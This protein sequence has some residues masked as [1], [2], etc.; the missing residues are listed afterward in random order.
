[1]H[2][3]DPEQLGDEPLYCEVDHESI[4]YSGSEDDY[5][6]APETRRLRIEA[7]AVQFLNGNVPYLLSA[8]LQGPFDKSSWT[9][10]WKSKRAERQ[11]NSCRA[12]GQRAVETVEAARADVIDNAADD[13][14]DTQ[15][16]NLYPLPSPETT[17]PPS[18]KKVP[19]LDE[20]EHDWI[21]EWRNEVEESS[22]PADPFRTFHHKTRPDASSTKKRPAN[23]EWLR[24]DEPKKRKSV[25]PMS[26]PPAESPS[27]AAAEARSRRTGRY[28]SVLTHSAPHSSAYYEDV[29][30]QQDAMFSSFVTSGAAKGPETIPDLARRSRILFY[31]ERISDEEFESSEDELSIPSITPTGRAARSSARK[32]LS[33]DYSP[34]R[35]R[36]QTN[37]AKNLKS[38][39]VGGNGDG[40]III[41]VPVD[42]RQPLDVRSNTPLEA[43]RA[44][45]VSRRVIGHSQQDSSFCFHQIKTKS[46]VKKG[47]HLPTKKHDP[48]GSSV[49]FSSLQPLDLATIAKSA[50]HQR[51]HAHPADLHGH[52]DKSDPERMTIDSHDHVQSPYDCS[53]DSGQVEECIDRQKT[54][55]DN[56]RTINSTENSISTHGECEIS[57]AEPWSQRIEDVLQDSPK[58]DVDVSNAEWST[59]I[60]TQDLA[61]MS[62]GPLSQNQG[63]EETAFMAQETSDEIDSDWATVVDIQDL[64]MSGPASSA[65]AK[66]DGYPP[67]F[68]QGPNDRS[69]TEWSTFLSFLDRPA[70]SLQQS[71]SS[72][73]TR[74]ALDGVSE[75]ESES[76]WSTCFSGSSQSDSEQ[77]GNTC[78]EPS[79]ADVVVLREKSPQAS[80]TSTVAVHTQAQEAGSLSQDN[81][82]TDISPY[83]VAGTMAVES[84][85]EVFDVTSAKAGESDPS[86]LAECA[87]LEEEQKIG[88]CCEAGQNQNFPVLV[89]NTDPVAERTANAS[90]AESWGPPECEMVDLN[91]PERGA[92]VLCTDAFISADTIIPSMKSQLL[93]SPW[94]KDGALDALL[95]ATPADGSSIVSEKCPGSEPLQEQSPW[96][97][98]HLE[99]PAQRLQANKFNTA[100]S[101]AESSDLSTLAGRALAL[102]VTP[103]TPWMGDKLPHPDFS[104]SVK[105]FSD[106]MKPSPIKKR[107]SPKQSILR[108]P[109]RGSN[110]LF[111]T[112]A[113]SRS[114]RR[115]TFAPLPGEG[116]NS[117]EDPGTQDSSSGYVEED[118]SYFDHDGE[119][120]TTVRV[121]RPATRPASPPPCDASSTEGGKIPDH[122]HKFAKH[123]EAMSKR[124]KD[125][126]Q[127]VPRL[128]P[129]DSP[130]VNSSQDVGAM[131][132]AFIQ[133]S[134][135]RRKGL[136]LNTASTGSPARASSN[137][138]AIDSQATAFC[139]E[140]L[141]EEQENT[142]PVDDVSAVL[143]NLDDFLDNT[144][145]MNLSMDEA[146]QDVE[147]G[148]QQT[149]SNQSLKSAS[150][151]RGDP[152]CTLD[153]N[154]WAD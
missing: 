58:A 126:L 149:A 65:A 134:Q 20:S 129:S 70:T 122:D 11:N 31:A 90:Q 32:S 21:Q 4:L 119:K 6:E 142:A 38:Q 106:F 99:T 56:A 121:T 86:V 88:G 101:E 124:N 144:W 74:G 66:V 136:E 16:T 62:P 116:A 50:A 2:L 14:P 51:R 133:A 61:I 77:T 47:Q 112:S 100:V 111:K 17:N 108:S 97:K 78:H 25:K 60:N 29:V 102:A 92:N 89:R 37:Q 113:P 118:I 63:Y 68:E 8:R 72:V 87:S 93:Q 1:M 54:Q 98:E 115:V 152:I 105:R 55:P 30:V 117:S 83:A 15:R 46:P 75:Y 57:E 131:A 43:P 13:L 9:N 59:Y 150:N 49:D 67:V 109:S 151:T 52:N 53:H 128:L 27:R 73:L 84:N 125:P 26:S 141:Q 34:S 12:S 148:F 114:Q 153:F 85:T 135:T 127:R 80:S 81:S 103:Q 19:R 42:V 24:K 82:P 147:P 154:V 48:S 120:T 71:E 23:E 28:S 94:T 41:P 69:D 130:K 10:P 104:L 22:T 139:A 107:A 44:T 140:G 35:R 3:R 146:A 143:D 45:R 145:G 33:P 95:Q 39:G 132:E 18:D 76:E 36:K 5:Y 79:S 96:F 123:F 110:I 7:K 138:S 91:T 64:A 137:C 40:G